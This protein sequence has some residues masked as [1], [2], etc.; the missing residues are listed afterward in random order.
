[1]FCKDKNISQ[2]FCPVGDHRGCGLLEHA[3]QTI[4]RRLGASR[5]NPDFSNVQDTLRHIFEDIQVTK[6]S[7]TRFSPFELHFSR[8]P[9]T[10]L[11]LAAERLSSRVNLD[12][13]QLERDLL[14]AEQCREQC[15]S[16]PRIKCVKKGQSS[17]SVSPCFGGPT[18]SVSETPHYRAL[19]SLA[20]SANQWLTLPKTMTHDEGVRALMILTEHKQVL[21]ATLRANLCSGTPRFRNQMPAEPIHPS[22]PKR[23]LD[24]LVLNDSSKLDIL[25]KFLNGKSGRVLFKHFKGKI[26][27]VTGSTYFTDKDKAIRRSHLEVRLKSK[28]V[29]FSDKQASQVKIGQK[30][31]IVSTSSSIPPEDN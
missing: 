28:S 30:R 23:I 6:K 18:E 21:A 20:K 9:N 10:E 16:R 17:P 26:V 24:F 13:Q 15:D 25:R 11:S 3:I 29:G 22:Q 31:H 12:D 27:K 1:M 5:L 7:V 2:I 8:P 4:K 14:T 19:E